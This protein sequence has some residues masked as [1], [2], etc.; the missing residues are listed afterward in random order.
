MGT[1]EKFIK[2]RLEMLPQAEELYLYY[3]VL[4]QFCRF[5]CWTTGEAIHGRIRDG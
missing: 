2:A 4:R 1:R 5:R 3:I